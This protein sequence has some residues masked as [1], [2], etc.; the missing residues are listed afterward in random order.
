MDKQINFRDISEALARS[1]AEMGAAECHG[2]CCGVLCASGSLNVEAMVAQLAGTNDSDS[3]YGGDVAGQLSVLLN[4][5]V[6]QLNGGEF[7]LRLLLP[8]D[9]DPLAE[10]SVALGLWCQGFVMGL[11]A[12]GVSEDTDLPKDSKELLLDFS[13]I[14][15]G[16]NDEQDPGQNDG[17]DE[18]E[19]AAYAEVEEYVRVG[20]LLIREELKSTWPEGLVH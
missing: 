2:M 19:E 13:S 15:S 9:D 16:L 18:E 12:G 5:T 17:D 20:V 4:A 10:R 8:D 6:V 11:S 7:D 1:N 3:S 14:A